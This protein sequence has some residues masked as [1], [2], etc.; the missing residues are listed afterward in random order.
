[1]WPKT[2]QSALTGLCMSTEMCGK[3][4]RVPATH[5]TSLLRREAF[6]VSYDAEAKM[7]H[8]S[9]TSVVILKDLDHYL[10]CN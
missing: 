2:A 5:H 9:H 4:L 10:F 7:A 6:S 1:M 8:I 3:V